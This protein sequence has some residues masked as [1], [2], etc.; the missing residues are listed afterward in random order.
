M[1]GI[2]AYGRDSNLGCYESYYKSYQNRCSYI[3]C[4]FEEIT[5]DDDIVSDA[6]SPFGFTAAPSP[7]SWT[8][9][10]SPEPVFVVKP[11]INSDWMNCSGPAP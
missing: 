5:P 11:Y 9:A 4:Y 8:E 2:S 6:P 10:P 1:N 3:S 7:E